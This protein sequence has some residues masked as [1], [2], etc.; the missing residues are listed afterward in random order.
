MGGRIAV[1][2]EETEMPDSLADVVIGEKTARE[3]GW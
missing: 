1:S 3:I 2:K